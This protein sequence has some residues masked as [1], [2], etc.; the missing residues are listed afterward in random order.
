MEVAA[1][2]LAKQQKNARKGAAAKA[3]KGKK[4]GKKAN[5]WSDEEDEAMDTESDEYE[6]CMQRGVWEGRRGRC[7]YRAAPGRGS[8]CG[9]PAKAAC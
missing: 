9:V 6:V 3:A 7:L 2:R 1:Q 5:P 4:G 8:G